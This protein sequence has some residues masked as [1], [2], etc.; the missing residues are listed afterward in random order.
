MNGIL[1]KVYKRRSRNG[2]KRARWMSICRHILTQKKKEIVAVYIFACT[3]PGHQAITFQ[4]AKVQREKPAGHWK[5]STNSF[6]KYAYLKDYHVFLVHSHYRMRSLSHFLPL[7]S[8]HSWKFPRS[9]SQPNSLSDSPKHHIM[10]HL[11]L[12]TAILETLGYAI[13][14]SLFVRWH[15]FCIFLCCYDRYCTL[16]LL[17]SYHLDYRFGGI[18]SYD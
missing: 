15:S 4:S 1:P 9:T 17:H 12:C 7:P 5:V 18:R 2:V 10:L 8:H 11:P 13:N 6:M 14:L 3:N 16:C